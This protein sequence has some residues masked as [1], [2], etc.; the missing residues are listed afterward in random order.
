MGRGGG[1]DRRLTSR[2][3]FSYGRFEKRL[4][5]GALLLW[6]VE[7]RIQ[8]VWIQCT[9]HMGQEEEDDRVVTSRQSIY[10]E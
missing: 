9:M 2:I 5:G 8:S 3:S 4:W 7:G 6:L 1:P 10:P